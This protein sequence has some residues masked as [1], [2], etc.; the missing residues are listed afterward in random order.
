MWF[1]ST[2]GNKKL[3]LHAVSEDMSKN[4]LRHLLAQQMLPLY[5]QCCNNQEGM[6]MLTVPD[7][8]QFTDMAT[9]LL[10]HICLHFKLNDHASTAF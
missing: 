9:T 2:F 5:Y 7:L 3:N 10:S 1:R 4:G 8:R 6:S